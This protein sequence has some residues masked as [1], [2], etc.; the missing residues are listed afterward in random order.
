MKGDSDGPDGHGHVDEDVDGGVT[1]G[2][3]DSY[4]RGRAI[5]VV[6]LLKKSTPG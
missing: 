1:E 2:R 6:E 5:A 4:P 3:S